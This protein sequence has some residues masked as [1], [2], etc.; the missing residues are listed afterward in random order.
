ME[1]LK[2]TVTGR[3]QGVSFRHYARLRARALGLTGWVRNERDGTVTTV[4]EGSSAALAAFYEFLQR[5]SPAARVD[6]VQAEWTTA[7]GDFHQFEARW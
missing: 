3:V 2:V 7:T 6:G 5:G 1:C 4:A